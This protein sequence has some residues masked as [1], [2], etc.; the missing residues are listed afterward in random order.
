MNSAQLGAIETVLRSEWLGTID[1][2]SALKKQREVLAAVKSGENP[3][4]LLLLEHPHVVTLGRRSDDS[5]LVTSRKALIDASVE[6]F[7][8]DRGGEA[9]YHGPGQLVGY[10]IID[11]R[12][13]GLGPVTYVRM[14][15]QTIIETLAEYGVE[16]HLV[17]GETGVWVGG[18]QNE[19]R[20][21]EN[22][23][24]KKIAAIGVR[25]TGGVTMHGLALNVST[26]LSYFQHIIPCG[27]PDLPFT[28]V[29]RE[30]GDSVTVRDC[31]VTIAEKL[32]ENLG[33]E[34]RW[35]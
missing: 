8:T 19:K 5:Q 13:A 33:R 23:V 20:G 25:I 7:E 3:D 32:A 29:E 27:M 10:P 24:G 21:E 22:P 15:E 18:T 35:D 30:L 4:S 31:S 11:V 16:G 14:L 26:D 17:D 28:T 9:T 2:E 6:I 12:A 1:Y 34:L